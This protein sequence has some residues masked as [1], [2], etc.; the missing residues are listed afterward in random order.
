VG[1][2]HLELLDAGATAAVDVDASPAYVEAARDEAARRGHAAQ[3]SYRVGDFVAA[4]PEVT[5]ADVVA[6][7]KVVCCYS[8][9]AALVTL[10]SARARRRYGLVYPRDAAWI[11]F[12]FVVA[13]AASRL[14]RSRTRIY[15]HRTADVD[16]LVR[17]AGLEPRF[18]R[19][20]VFWQVVAYERPIV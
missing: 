19:K 10:S 18:L 20:T 6:L 9:M 3:V 12:G 2:V 16:A 14:F 7:D 17:G 13:N 11:R 15:S 1:A 4:A 8:D 5:P